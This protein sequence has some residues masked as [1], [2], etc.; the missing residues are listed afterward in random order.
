MN[1]EE[2]QKLVNELADYAEDIRNDWSTFDGRELR[3]YINYDWIPRLTKELDLF[4]DE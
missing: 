3:N 4:E 1:K 2:I